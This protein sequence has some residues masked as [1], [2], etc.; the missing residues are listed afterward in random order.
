MTSVDTELEAAADILMSELNHRWYNGL[1]VIAASLRLFGSDGRAMSDLCGQLQAQAALHR[2]LSGPPPCDEL[3]RYCRALCLDVLLAFGRT[4]ITPRVSMAA[5][6]LSPRCARHLGLLVVELMTNALKHGRA[7]TENGVVSVTL[8]PV[9]ADLELVV[10]DNFA[11]PAAP[12]CATPRIALALAE[13][14]GGALTVEA[15][16]GYVTRVHFPLR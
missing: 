14:L 5:V 4:E 7:P 8:R 12:L 6:L 13:T 9:G 11:P 1:Q 3:E 15:A 16:P 10:A 2:R